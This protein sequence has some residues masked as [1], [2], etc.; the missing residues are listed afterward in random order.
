MLDF[1][2][3]KLHFF[4]AWSSRQNSMDFTKTLSSSISNSADEGSDLTLKLKFSTDLKKFLS[5][6]G[7][8]NRLLSVRQWMKNF[9]YTKNVFM[10]FQMRD[11]KKETKCKSFYSYINLAIMLNN[12]GECYDNIEK[13]F[14]LSIS[15]LKFEQSFAIVYEFVYEFLIVLIYSTSCKQ[16]SIVEWK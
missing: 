12:K 8:Y 5:E 13:D 6:E 11:A 15:D 14:N 4:R 16:L 10:H 1:P 3:K 7:D 2:K 9:A